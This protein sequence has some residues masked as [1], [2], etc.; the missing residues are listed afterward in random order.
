VDA[1][2]VSLIIKSLDGLTTRSVAIAQNIANASSRGYRPLSVSF[3][4]AL[5]RAAPQGAAAVDAVTPKIDTAGADSV[6]VDLELANASATTQRYGAL[7]DA[8]SRE[9]QLQQ[10]AIGGS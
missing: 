4:A 3:E 5:A 2:S 7:V 6:R 1:L 8:L 10:I 9:L